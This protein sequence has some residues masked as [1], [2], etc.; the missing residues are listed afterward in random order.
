MRNWLSAVA[1]TLWR[2]KWSF[3]APT[4][5]AAA[6]TSALSYYFLPTRYRSETVIRV[7]SPGTGLAGTTARSTDAPEQLRR[8]AETALTRARLEG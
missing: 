8:I 7:Q 3:I 4:L 1:G 5:V 6:A 2:W